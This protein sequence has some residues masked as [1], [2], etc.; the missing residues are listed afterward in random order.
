M[1]HISMDG[2]FEKAIPVELQPFYEAWKVNYI[3]P[4]TP[5]WR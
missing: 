5:R 2:E 3:E 4:P 1:P